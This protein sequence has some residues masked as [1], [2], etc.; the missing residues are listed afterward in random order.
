M[1]INTFMARWRA[2]GLP[3]SFLWAGDQ[4]NGF[5]GQSPWKKYL[6]QRLKALRPFG[7]ARVVGEGRYGVSK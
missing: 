3:A 4:A 6:P 5:T 2:T 1:K 7:R